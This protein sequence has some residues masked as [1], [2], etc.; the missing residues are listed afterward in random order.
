MNGGMVIEAVDIP[1]G[2]PEFEVYD[3]E[4]KHL[5]GYKYQCTA[6]T[7]QGDM[8]VAAPKWEN[9]P[10]DMS[11]A[12]WLILMSRQEIMAGVIV[13]TDIWTWHDDSDH[14]RMMMELFIECAEKTLK[15]FGTTTAAEGSIRFNRATNYLETVVCGEWITIQ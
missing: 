11:V 5:G 4:V 15:K 9:K 1:E 2:T 13:Y 8:P 7:S 12:A 6:K 14:Y 3:V 10:K